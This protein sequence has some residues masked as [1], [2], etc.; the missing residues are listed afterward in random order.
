MDDTRLL[1]LPIRLGIQGE[2]TMNNQ[3]D[4]PRKQQ[5]DCVNRYKKDM[6]H[7]EDRQYDNKKQRAIL[8]K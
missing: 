8:E 7:I 1:E 6:M 3:Q 2:D 4:N 5:E